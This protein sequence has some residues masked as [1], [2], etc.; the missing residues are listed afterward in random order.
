M[1]KTV[2]SESDAVAG[3]S[4]ATCVPKMWALLRLPRFRGATHAN[5]LT[6]VRALQLALFSKLT[7]VTF[8]C[9]R[10]PRAPKRALPYR[11]AAESALKVSLMHCRGFW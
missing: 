7:F 3:S 9:L 5:I 2:T 8:R 11:E 6:T 1:A 4:T 10:W